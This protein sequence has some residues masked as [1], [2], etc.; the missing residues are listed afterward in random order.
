MRKEFEQLLAESGGWW[1]HG[2]LIHFARFTAMATVRR[3]LTPHRLSVDQIDWESIAN[4]ALLIL[5]QQAPRILH[6]PHQN[7]L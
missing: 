7:L 1:G 6:H 4:E 2:S 3:L 5:F